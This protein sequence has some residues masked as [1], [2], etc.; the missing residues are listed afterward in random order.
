MG[1]PLL[2]SH[3][4]AEPRTLVD[5]L[6]ATV[7]AHPD[8]RAI[9]NGREVLTYEEAL[10]AADAVAR[11]LK[12]QG[13][14]RGDTVGIRIPS[15]TTDLYVA[16]LGVLCAGAAYV[17]VDHD[18]PEERARVVFREAGVA[19]VLTADLVI[20]AAAADVDPAPAEDPGL[21]D[22]AWVIF[23]SGSTGT[24]KGVAVSH[25]SAAAFVDAEA[26]MFFQESPIRPG[27]RVMAGLSV[28]FDASCE[29]MWLAWR[30]GACLV[31]APRSL[32]RSGMDLGPWLLANGITVVSTVPTLVALWP[33]EALD[34]VRLLILGGEACPPEIGARLATAEREVW[35][36]Y[37]PTEA[38]VVACGA[39]LT[40]EPPVRIG[41]PLNGWDLAVVGPD[42][43][44]VPPGDPGELIIGGVGLARYLDPDKDAA[45]Y[46]P[47]P[48]LGWDRAYRSGDVVRF[49]GVGLLF[50]G[51]ADDQV[52]VG[53]RRIELGEID[54]A[55][56]SLPG[57]S[58]ADGLVANYAR[59]F[60]GSD[61]EFVRDLP[62]RRL[63]IL[64]RGITDLT[65]VHNLGSTLEELHVD[66][67]P[68]LYID[69]TL[70]PRLRVLSCSWDQVKDT[71]DCTDRLEDLYLSPYREP[72]L[73]AL[74]HLTSLR[75]LRMKPPLGVRS[76]DGVETM[77]W[78]AHLGMYRAPL[79]DTTALARLSSPVLTGPQ[80]VG[81]SVVPAADFPVGR[82]RP[83]R[84]PRPRRQ[85]ER[86]DREP[87]SDRRP[88]PD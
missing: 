17:P 86:R 81:P 63:D 21:D 57:G 61:I 68:G 54:S 45:V 10:E 41:L 36:T 62:L 19:A 8:A 83:G 6:R 7:H 73:L 25:R 30:H 4:A 56:L 18:D 27:D 5:V 20:R 88:H 12:E 39:R 3:L 52:K 32:V 50:Q 24:P 70:L 84:T 79:E 23:T 87:G 71:I 74:K 42:G 2:R 65:P 44:R 1:D 46:A 16:V 58:G 49:D 85:R 47:M 37:G 53:G 22:D 69:L 55:L 76:L 33:T 38:T 40:G 26:R 82:R 59:G 67:A 9:D 13:I 15:G 35:N 75:S 77:P 80:Q 28:A 29:E 11:G 66:V 51:R 78:L 60:V 31:P 64:D 72:D 48:A 14:G 34:A 43:R